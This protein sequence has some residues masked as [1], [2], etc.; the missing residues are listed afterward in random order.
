M[1]LT[2]LSG[3]NSSAMT[4]KSYLEIYNSSVKSRDLTLDVRTSSEKKLISPK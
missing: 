1:V 2:R 4:R 3:Y